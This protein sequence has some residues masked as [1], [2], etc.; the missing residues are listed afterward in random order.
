MKPVYKLERSLN[1]F[2]RHEDQPKS[3]PWIDPDGDMWMSPNL[4]LTADRNDWKNLK[5]IPASEEETKH[6]HIYMKLRNL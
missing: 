1:F 5:V 6:Y 4:F 3:F 2:Y